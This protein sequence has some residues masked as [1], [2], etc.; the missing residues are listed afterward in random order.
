MNC[1]TAR[2]RIL[3]MAGRPEPEIENHLRACPSCAQMRQEQLAL[4]RRLD[5]W[6][7]PEISPGFEARLFRRMEARS[8]WF[9]RWLGPV[10]PAFAGALACLVLLAGV[11][12]DRARHVPPPPDQPVA[13]QGWDREDLRQM[14]TALDDM[15]ML[16]EFE[17][18]PVA[19]AGEGKS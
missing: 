5:E 16:S 15:Q 3:E 17:I 4:W 1:Q 8:S 11:V 19:Q 9:T 10:Q 13:I 12:L 2:D 6:T 7:A 14:D 18:L